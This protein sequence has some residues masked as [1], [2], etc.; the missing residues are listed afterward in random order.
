LP[1]QGFKTLD[2][3]ILEDKRKI[4]EG[5]ENRVRELQELEEKEKHANIEIKFC[6]MM[7]EETGELY[8]ACLNSIPSV[9]K[10]SDRSGLGFK[11]AMKQAFIKIP[12]S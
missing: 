1:P 4:V 6:E 9:F 2:E 10:D 8:N 11:T 12:N 3:R 5:L 7:G